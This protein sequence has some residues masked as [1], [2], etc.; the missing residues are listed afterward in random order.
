MARL[1]GPK[2]LVPSMSAGGAVLEP[3]PSISTCTL[4]YMPRKSSDQ[5]AMRLFMVSEPMLLM[6]PETPLVLPY[7]GRSESTDTVCPQ[8]TLAARTSIKPSRRIFMVS[9]S[10]R[11]EVSRR[12]T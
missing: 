10:F 1:M 9:R 8:A 2:L 12:S 3:L 5:R 7:D 11:I 6:E 4:G